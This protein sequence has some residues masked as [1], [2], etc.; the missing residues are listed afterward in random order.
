MAAFAHL[1]QGLMKLSRV[2]NVRARSPVL[3]SFRWILAAG[4]VVCLLYLAS[5]GPVAYWTSRYSVSSPALDKLYKPAGWVF[6]TSE[7]YSNYVIWF[8]RQGPQA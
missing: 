5:L 3:A 6:Q 1:Q 2:S 8:G 7:V 4:G